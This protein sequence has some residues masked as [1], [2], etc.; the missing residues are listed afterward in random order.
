MTYKDSTS[1]QVSKTLFVSQVSAIAIYGV[2]SAIN[3]FSASEFV[4][5]AL[6]LLAVL[7]MI[8]VV[9]VFQ[10]PSYFASRLSAR[11]LSLIAIIFSL[12]ALTLA[13]LDANTYLGL[14]ESLA[15][16]RGA[17]NL[18][19]IAFLGVITF[20]LALIANLLAAVVARR[21]QLN[22]SR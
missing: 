9:I 18:A 4:P 19:T 7:A 14:P 2:A 10:L 5:G 15:S 16:S 17:Q 8:S 12:F 21:Q 3:A 1:W 22:L 11:A 20:A 13:V 6:S